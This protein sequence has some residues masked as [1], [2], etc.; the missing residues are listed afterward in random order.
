MRRL[1]AATVFAVL[2]LAP[3]ASAA[4]V[5]FVDGHGWGHGIGLAQYGAQGF[6]TR[7]GRDHAWIL[8]HYYRGTTLSTTSVTTVRVLLVE[9]R[10][11]VG[12]GSDAPY[13]VTD[14]NDRTYTLPAGRVTL[15]SP[16]RVTVDG[17]THTLASP[18]RFNR[19]GRVLDLGGRPYR[20]A[21]VV[22]LA[23]GRLSVVNHVGV[24]EYLYGVVP[25]E[26]PPSWAPEALKAQA[27]AA[28]TY[29]LVSRRTGG[30]F[31]LFS[32]TR[33]QVYG[34]VRSEDARANAAIDATAGKV[35]T[36][37]GRLAWTFFHST[38]GGR[39]ASIQHVWNA[40]PIPYLVSVPDPHDDLSPHHSW[41]PFRYT[42]AQLR[43]K[44]GALAPRGALLDLTVA[45]NASLR[46]GSVTARGSDGSTTF[47]GTT[48][49]TR[50]GLRSSWF[51]VSVL[52][53]RGG[54]RVE[55]GKGTKLTGIAR[56]FRA[57]T[58]EQ[59]VAGG[60]WGSAAPLE[61]RPDGTFAVVAKP[62]VTTWYRIRTP[63]GTSAEHRV[64]VAPAV[65]FSE[66]A[67]RRSL[68]GFVRPK[69]A[70]TA[71]TVQRFANGSWRVVARARTDASGAFRA[72]LRVVPGRYR[73][74]AVVGPGWA[75]GVSPVLTVAPR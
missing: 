48:F 70:G 69:R 45:R 5:F 51:S 24:E 6:A 23:G 73:A 27:V 57:A 42:A 9:G 20:G 21:L 36:H 7:D 30:S 49:Q 38:S 31:D 59:R 46:A 66:L 54:G 25:D 3:G 61:R 72:E 19:G 55:F 44:L 29:A 56:G 52:A 63:K 37:G 8:A 64:V 68:A 62:R 13:T 34:G 4:P 15:G 16:L 28:R 12:V 22:S 41:G 65:R 67:D 71:V 53:F 11:S 47:A 58:I 50:L 18:V 35:V 39:T 32:D 1:L 26:M 43:A 60:S 10:T 17:K 2:A 75:R 74:L 33:S 40:D 14:A